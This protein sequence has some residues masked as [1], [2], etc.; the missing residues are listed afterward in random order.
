MENAPIKCKKTF[1]QAYSKMWLLFAVSTVDIGAPVFQLPPGAAEEINQGYQGLFNPVS[2]SERHGVS[3]KIHHL[4]C[5]RCPGAP[6]FRRL[7][8]LG[9]RLSCFD[10]WKRAF[11]WYFRNGSCFVRIGLDTVFPQVLP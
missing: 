9:D 6:S 11:G 10:Y 7:C 4:R 5:A 1:L 3:A 2:S 8:L